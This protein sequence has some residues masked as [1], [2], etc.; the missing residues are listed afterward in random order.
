MLDNLSLYALDPPCLDLD[1]QRDW[2]SCI[3]RVDLRFF[4]RQF[5][6]IYYMHW[7][8]H[9]WT[10]IIRE[11]GVLVLIGLIYAFLLDN[12]SLYALDPPCLDLDDQRDWRSCTDRVDLRFLAPYLLQKH[13][14][15]N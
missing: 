5:V 1:N 2:R 6:S 7:I 15:Q 8:H 9:V 3:D 12:L 10:W 14:M 11:T 13:C 4:A